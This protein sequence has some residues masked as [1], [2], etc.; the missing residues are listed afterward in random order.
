LALSISQDC[1]TGDCSG[2]GVRQGQWLV[3]SCRSRYTSCHA[4][5]QTDRSSASHREPEDVSRG[6]ADPV[7]SLVGGQSSS[8]SSSAPKAAGARARSATQSWQPQVSTS[9]VQN[10]IRS[11]ETGT[12]GWPL[13]TLP[14]QRVPVSSSS[15]LP[16]GFCLPVRGCCIGVA[17][18]TMMIYMPLDRPTGFVTV[19][20]HTVS[21]YRMHLQPKGRRSGFWYLHFHSTSLVP[22]RPQPRPQ[23]AETVYRTCPMMHCQQP[24]HVEPHWHPCIH[25]RTGS[26]AIISFGTA[27]CVC[28]SREQAIHDPTGHTAAGHGTQHD[29]P[30][31]RS[32]RDPGQSVRPAVKPVVHIHPHVSVCRTLPSARIHL[33]ST[34]VRPAIHDRTLA[35]PTQKGSRRRP[36]GF[37]GRPR[38][39]SV[40]HRLT[41]Q[42][43]QRH[44]STH[45]VESNAP[46]P[47]SPQYLIATAKSQSLGFDRPP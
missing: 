17:C 26:L 21:L 43:N 23:P 19:Q 25:D 45:L 18:H 27:S 30:A 15:S 12:L 32:T 36:D 31:A 29:G 1:A 46:M 11:C 2:G 10:T 37:D 13:L 14:M 20:K 33:P 6:S 3:R 39:P 44:K 35:A 5:R 7:G 47:I 28:V 38:R 34:P 22:F 4:H 9:S 16:A 24:S 42:K 40:W 8:P 41:A